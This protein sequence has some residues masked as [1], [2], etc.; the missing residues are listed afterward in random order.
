MEFIIST[1]R[2]SNKTIT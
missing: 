2:E 1:L